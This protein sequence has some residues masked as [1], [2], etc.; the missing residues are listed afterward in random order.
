MALSRRNKEVYDPIRKKWVIATPEELVRQK[1]LQLLTRELGYPP[2]AIAIEKKLSRLPRLRQ[3]TVPPRR[4]DVVCYETDTFRPLL[5]IECK[6]VPLREK[7]LAQ[8][9]G[10]NAFIKAP[11][12]CLAN[13]GEFLLGWENP[14]RAMT[15]DRLPSYGELRHEIPGTAEAR[16]AGIC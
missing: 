12:I 16:P 10:Y 14:K 2:H 6:G 7:M 5:L 3:A 1:I 15:L 4:L 8:V 13:E 11:L 9:M